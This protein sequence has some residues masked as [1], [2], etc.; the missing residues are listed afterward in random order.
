MDP[1]LPQPRTLKSVKDPPTTI[2]RIASVWQ[3]HR[4]SV[5]VWYADTA[6]A[7]TLLTA[8]F[9]GNQPWGA[10]LVGVSVDTALCD[11]LVRMR[12]RLGYAVWVVLFPTF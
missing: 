9:V 2:L 5:L 10:A 7:G 1:I 8:E 12:G 4:S 3:D 11:P 6:V